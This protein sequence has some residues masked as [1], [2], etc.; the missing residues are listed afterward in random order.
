VTPKP[1]DVPQVAVKEPQEASAHLWATN[2]L[3]GYC[4]VPLLM[5]TFRMQHHVTWCAI[6][7]QCH[8]TWCATLAA[9]DYG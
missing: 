7:M 3:G 1:T 9:I 6:G 8:F 2:R 5:H 4:P